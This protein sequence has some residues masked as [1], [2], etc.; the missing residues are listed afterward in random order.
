MYESRL[1]FRRVYEADLPMLGRWLLSPAVAR[2]YP[3]AHY[4]EDLEDQLGDSRIAMNLVLLD[5]APVAYVQD[6]DIHAWND[7]PLSFLPLGARGLDTFIGEA[8]LIGRRLGSAYLRA[9]GDA[10]FAEGA[11][12]L[13]ID[14]A[15][16]NYVAQRAFDKAGFVRHSVAQTEWARVILMARLPPD[17]SAP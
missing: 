15:E 6:Y 10:L 14:P 16:E 8:A 3:D 12:A 1:T 4:I 9:R 5:G 7:H 2:W 13:G 11:P 17:V